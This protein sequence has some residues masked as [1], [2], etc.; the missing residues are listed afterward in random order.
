MFG[1]IGKIVIG[2]LA[3]VGACCIVKA[4]MNMPPYDE[5]CCCGD[6]KAEAT[7]NKSKPDKSKP[8]NTKPNPVYGVGKFEPHDP[9]CMM[10]MEHSGTADHAVNAARCWFAAGNFTVEQFT[11]VKENL[12]KDVPVAPSE[13]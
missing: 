7:E 10:A 11:E 4:I 12:M 6:Y 2:S 3:L 5:M 1:K 9:Y 8:D 13:S